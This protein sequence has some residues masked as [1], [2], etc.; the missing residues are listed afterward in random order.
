MRFTYNKWAGH[1]NDNN[2]TNVIQNKTIN[3]DSMIIYS[4]PN[5][6][7]TTF[8]AYIVRGLSAYYLLHIVKSDS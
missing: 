7:W 8:G 5:F 4:G 1:D 3:L 6:D 2:G